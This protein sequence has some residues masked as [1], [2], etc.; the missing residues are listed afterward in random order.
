MTPNDIQKVIQFLSR[1]IYLPREQLNCELLLGQINCAVA[2]HREFMGKEN[3]RSPQ[4]LMERILVNTPEGPV[5]VSRAEGAR[6]HL[7]SSG[8]RQ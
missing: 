2:L 1:P 8:R 4:S 7:Q 5:E 3:L 6:G